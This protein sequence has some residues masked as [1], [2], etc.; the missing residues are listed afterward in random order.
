MNAIDCAADFHRGQ[1]LPSNGTQGT[2]DCFYYARTLANCS[3]ESELAA[4]AG[5]TWHQVIAVLVG[6]PSIIWLVLVLVDMWR[7]RHHHH[8]DWIMWVTTVIALFVLINRTTWPFIGPTSYWGRFCKMCWDNMGA[9]AGICYILF[10]TLGLFI[11]VHQHQRIKTAS[12]LARHLWPKRVCAIFAACM[13][14]FEIVCTALEYAGGIICIY[15]YNIVQCALIM[16]GVVTLTWAI[17]YIR[18]ALGARCCVTRRH[19]RTRHRCSQSLK[20]MLF[21]I[22]LDVGMGGVVIFVLYDTL[23]GTDMA[24]SSGVGY[25]TYF[26]VERLLEWLAISSVYVRYGMRSFHLFSETKCCHTCAR[27]CNGGWSADDEEEGASSSN[28]STTTAIK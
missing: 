18:K 4:G 26:S 17:I 14:A 25:V 19:D 23:A 21:A 10:I 2:C 24:S 9:D 22:V 20:L 11:D 16:F 3:L 5:W 15:A 27:C 6:G 12:P 8:F 7:R 28:T 1:C 13:L